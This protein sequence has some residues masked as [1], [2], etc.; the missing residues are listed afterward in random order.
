[1]NADDGN[2]KS[3]EA[4]HGL[5]RRLLEGDIP[6]GRE[7]DACRAV[8]NTV[9]SGDLATQALCML[10]EGALADAGMGIEDTQ[11]LVPLLKELAQGTVTPEEVL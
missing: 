8:L 2:A 5:V 4:Y 3:I 9:P 7:F 6:H 1:M 10:L 11:T